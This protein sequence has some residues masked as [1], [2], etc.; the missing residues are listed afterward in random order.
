MDEPQHPSQQDPDPRGEWQSPAYPPPPTQPARDP[1]TLAL[2][3]IAVFAAIGALVVGVLALIESPEPA[4]EA[5]LGDGS[6]GTEELQDEAVTAD[7]V[8]PGAIRTEALAD[9]AVRRAKLR[10]GAV[11]PAKVVPDSLGAGQIDESSLEQLPSAETAD[12]A[13]EAGTAETALSLEGFDPDA[14]VPEV[15]TAEAVTDATSDDA[16]AQ[17]ADCPSGTTVLSGGASIETAGNATLPVAVGTSAPTATGWSALAFETAP[18]EED[19]SLRVVAL[20]ATLG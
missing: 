5:P 8:A 18:V 2:A 6:V 13:T 16:K 17:A 11:T 19:W 3:T 1:F 20:C 10:N 9:G 7:K 15:E 12:F 4:E 14:I